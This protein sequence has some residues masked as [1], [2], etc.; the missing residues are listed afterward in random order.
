MHKT[1]TELYDLIKDIRTKKDFEKELKTRYKNYDGLL[2]EAT[3][4]LLMVDELGRNK[5]SID[6][7]AELEPEK[8]YTVV[9]TVRSLSDTRA[10][11]RKNGTAGKVINLE[12]SDDTGI[13]RLVLWNEDIEH[14][15]KKEIQPGTTVK[16]ING[17]TKQGFAGLEIHLGRWGLL[18]VE[19]VDI[20][21]PQEQQR[22][23]GDE[24]NGI[25][26]SKEATRAFFKD[27]GEFGFV[28]AITLN[29]NGQEKRIT[30]WDRSVKDIQQ[31]KIGEKIILKNV[32]RKQSNGKAEFHVNGNSTIRKH[33]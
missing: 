15:K 10:F 18:E 31:F 21:L 3:I 20:S 17:Y 25:L 4:A 23:N 19:P 29:D 12:I 2:D 28:T 16:I 1:K 32:T 14:I 7:I 22:H 9:G 8:E 24:I 33:T 30:L 5:Q 6:K 11:K 26:V 13:C 27:D